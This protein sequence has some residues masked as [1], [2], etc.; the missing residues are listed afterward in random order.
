MKKILWCL[1]LLLVSGSLRAAFVDGYQDRRGTFLGVGVGGAQ[2]SISRDQGSSLGTVGATFSARLG[3]GIRKDL[4]VDAEAIHWMGRD[5]KDEI[6]YDLAQTAFLV[7]A[8]RLF[9][10]GF[11]LRGG[12][13]F[14]VSKINPNIGS[15]KS[16]SGLAAQLGAGFE[17]FSGVHSA[18]QV[19]LNWR[20][21]Y[22]QDSTANLLGLQVGM[23]W[24]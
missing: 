3:A 13:G 15:S 19:G 12:A 9:P 14:S 8:T 22:L 7:N 24:Y 11:Y 23:T 18:M 17:V 10:D 16:D 20:G 2:A 4:L 5:S 6:D 1:G 21:H